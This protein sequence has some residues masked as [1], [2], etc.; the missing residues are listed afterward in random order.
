[1]KLHK[2]WNDDGAFRFRSY[3]LK[4][5][6][7][8]SNSNLSRRATQSRN[9]FLHFYFAKANFFFLLCRCVNIAPVLQVHQI[10]SFGM[11]I[12]PDIYRY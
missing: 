12:K 5:Q 7:P 6:T 1:M 9:V 4:A 8:L 11:F 3:F 10:D 2:Q